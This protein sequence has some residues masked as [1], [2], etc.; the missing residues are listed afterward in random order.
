M[1]DFLVR[2]DNGVTLVLE[3]KGYDPLEEVKAQAA[4][5]WVDAVNADGRYGEWRYATAHEMGAV[6]GL[7]DDTADRGAVRGVSA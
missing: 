3:T 2:L 4:Q 5:R 6:S 7:I 1:P